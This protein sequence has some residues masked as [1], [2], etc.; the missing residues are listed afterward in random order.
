M[1]TTMSDPHLETLCAHC[2]TEPGDNGALVAPIWQTAVWTAGSAE[3]CVQILSGE[4]DGY[5]YTR[6]ANPNNRA[7]ERVIARLE[8]A[9]DAVV[10]SSGMAALTASVAAFAGPGSRVVAAQ[11][12]YGASSRWL[13]DELARFGV[14]IISLPL[15]ELEGMR[16]AL[17][18]GEGLLLVETIS[19]PLMQAADL[20]ALGRLC[21]ETGATFVVDNTFAT[22]LFCRPLEWGAD[23]V[24]HSA[25]KFIGGHSDLTLGAA[26][27]SPEICARL[28]SMASLWGS[29]AAPLESWLALRGV[30]TLPLRMERSSANALELA[31]RLAAHPCVTAVNYPG[32]ATSVGQAPVY[33][34]LT[35]GGAMLSFE[36][37]TGDQARRLLRELRQVP[38]APSL[39]DVATT[40]SYPVATSHRNVEE[41]ELAALKITPGLLRLSV[42]IDHVDDVWADLDRA[43]SLACGRKA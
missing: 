15:D 23:V 3:Q 22:P 38:F 25:T 26:A 35:G 24:V 40:I 18:R 10:F 28:R 36:L 39:G 11:P 4:A 17:G 41:S 31:R 20:P 12:L 34:H 13:R 29:N 33:P 32:L 6:D 37:A 30:T 16:G 14:E 42:G 8:A 27:A 7:L 1:K 19:N 21:K 9:G 2:R 5:I 43:I